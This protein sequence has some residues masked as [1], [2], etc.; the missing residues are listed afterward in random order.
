[1]TK[2]RTFTFLHKQCLPNFYWI[3]RKENQKYQL[4]EYY[5]KAKLAMSFTTSFMIENTGILEEK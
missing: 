1:M 2:K 4:A 3:T 5:F